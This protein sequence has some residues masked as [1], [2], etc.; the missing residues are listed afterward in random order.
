[1]TPVSLLPPNPSY[2]KPASLEHYQ[3]SNKRAMI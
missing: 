3:Y 1:M 2:C